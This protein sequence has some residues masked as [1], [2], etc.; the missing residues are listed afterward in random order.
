MDIRKRSNLAAGIILILVGAVLL[1]AQFVPD[2]FDWL[3]PDRNWP[4]IV[5]GVG[6]VLLIVGLVTGVPA[7]AVP[8]C[9]V[10]GIGGILY[11]QNA[12]GYWDSWAYAWTLIP[13]FVGA[14]IILSGLLGGQPRKALL[15]G[16]R[17]VMV[18]LV[19]FAIFGFIF[20]R[21]HFQGVLWPSLIIGVGVIILIRQF[22]G[23]R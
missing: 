11:W 7:L 5:I 2:L 3:D 16:G 19:L 4:L 12:T 22:L 23:V 17:T 18:S 9:I 15:E 14:G 20:A 1:A 13:G 8:A 10:G 6:I 21:D